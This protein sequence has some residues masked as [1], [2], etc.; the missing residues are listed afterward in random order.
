MTER[1]RME[2]G[3]LYVPQGE[4][5]RRLYDRAKKLT[6]VINNPLEH[7]EE[8]RKANFRELFGA[9]GER[10]WI[11]PP[12]YC[13]YGYTIHIGDGFA[14]NYGCVIID[15]AAV[16]IGNNSCWDRRSGFIRQGIRSRL[17]YGDAV[18]SSAGR[19]SLAM[20]FGSAV[21]ARSIRALRSA[22]MLSSD[23][24]RSLPGTSPIRLSLPAIPAVFCAR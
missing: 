8:R 16:T 14:A 15:V 24:A 11:A 3:K 1:E 6:G 20:M 2:A 12:F 17:P 23:R 19:S 22:A 9:I 5:L 21:T 10:F 4:E 7:D 13:D 18:W